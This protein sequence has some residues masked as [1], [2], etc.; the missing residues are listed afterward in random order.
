MSCK[1]LPF[2]KSKE[3]L[4]V[5]GLLCAL[6][7]IFYYD[8]VFLGKTFKATTVN[9]QALPYGVYGQQN[10]KPR[11][12]PTNGTDPSVLEEPIYEFIKQSLKQGIVPLWNPHQAAGYALI[13]M[14]QVGMF[15]PL[16]FILYLLPNFFG[17]DV[18]IF[19]RMLCGGLFV[20]WMMRTF[21]FKPIP[22]VGSAVIYMFTG[23]MVLMHYWF[24]NVDIIAPLLILSMERLL[25]TTT[26]RNLIF[27]AVAVAL[28]FF[29]GH[30]EHIFLV[31]AFAFAFLCYRMMAL[32]RSIQ[33][34]K[35][36]VYLLCAYTLGLGL[37]AMVL[38]PFLR[39]FVS[40]FW[41]AHPPGVGLL[42]EEVR[43][44]ALTLA[45]PH[46][47][48]K[49]S[50]DFNFQFAGWWGGYL[51]TI[52]LAL[53]FLSLFK[54]QK[55]GLNYF[56]GISTVVIIGKSYNVPV[57]NLIGYLPLFNLCRFAIHTLH[58]SSL[59]VAVLGGMGI[60]MICA[61][62]HVFK[63]GL[64]YSGLLTVIVAIHLYIFRGAAYRSL[65][66]N[67][68]IFAL[69][70]LMI[71][72][73]ILL[74]RDKRWLS[75]GK[76]SVL[77]VFIIL[78]ELFCY[79]HREH[80]KRFDS[81]PE[82][83]YIEFLRNQPERQR[84]Y[85]VLWAFYPNTATSY[86]VDD[87]G[88]FQ[89]F[90]PIRFVKTVNNLVLR[91]N[92]KQNLDMHSP[93][94]RTISLPDTNELL[95]VLNVRYLIGPPD[96]DGDGLPDLLIP[97]KEPE[98][99]L[100]IKVNLDKPTWLIYNK[101]VSVYERTNALPRAFIVH[102]VF[103]TPTEQELYDAVK[104]MRR[105]LDQG[106][107]ILHEPIAPIVQQLSTVPMSDNSKA[108]ITQYTPNEVVV[109]AHLENPGFLVLGDAYHSDWKVF[110]NGKP[111]KIYLADSLV[112]AVYLPAGEHKVRF[113]FRPL[114]FYWGLA[115]S[116]TSM[117]I[118]IFLLSLARRKRLG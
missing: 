69:A 11:F 63:K 49:E 81:F 77:I 102:R 54:R 1:L 34:R 78:F 6:L 91:N 112:R 27:M 35:C 28:T 79:I 118:I 68:S 36:L 94:L 86:Q 92:F 58:L 55:R 20:Y 21:R 39:N 70:L 105:M 96:T 74:I 76:I 89:D 65:S 57:I 31:N 117:A 24:V 5:I 19:A 33:I 73:L 3:N 23:P 85:G 7:A 108:T 67:A 10:N 66:I 82:V 25:R 38:F 41:H 26:K 115:I 52:P 87:F 107:M 40:E 22:S 116:F 98:K 83:P 53:G 30:P 113:V 16:H 72:Q 97:S 50:L 42:L 104:L 99:L 62:K 109:Q 88:I 100:K 114:S 45:L 90:L 18:F 111:E 32:R 71:F 47:F 106:I 48:Q 9:S 103:F 95:N 8:V 37:S 61:G 64:V 60:R 44:R 12:I 84:A 14:I 2:N 56:F 17:W 46:F 15:F 4:I 93:A 80:V 13:G 101:E 59:C 110:V 51:G 29:G 75:R 43:E